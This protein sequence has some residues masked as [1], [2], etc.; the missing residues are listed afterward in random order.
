MSNVLFTRTDTPGSKP[1]TD[2]QVLFDTS[3][4]GKMY[5][6]NGTDRLEMGGAITVDQTLSKIST[7][8]IANKGVA[9]VMLES[10]DDVKN[11]TSKGFLVDALPIKELDNNKVSGFTQDTYSAVTGLAYDATKK[12]LGL[13][14][15]A[16]TVIPFSGGATYVFYNFNSSSATRSY[17]FTDRPSLVYV[18]NLGSAKLPP[19][20]NGLSNY[21]YQWQQAG[22]GYW[23]GFFA[24]AVPSSNTITVT[25]RSTNKACFLMFW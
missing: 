13:K 21:N 17:T 11:V 1:I 23:D 16:D 3:G 9:G 6:D 8:P 19:T 24:T 7:N 5:L 2:G 18:M 14:V 15:G 10:L 22:E 20:I 25:G 12:K 4:N